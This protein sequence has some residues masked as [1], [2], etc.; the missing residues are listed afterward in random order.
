[1]QP[2]ARIILLNYYASLRVSSKDSKRKVYKAAMIHLSFAPKQFFEDLA[3]NLKI[4]LEDIID[5]FKNS[6]IVKFFAKIGW[7][8]KKLYDK[9]KQSVSSL[10]SFTEVIK[11]FEQNNKIIRWTNEWIKKLDEHFKKDPVGKRIWG[12]TLGLALLVVFFMMA[13][14]GNPTYD[15]D[16]SD[17]IELISGKFSLVSI[18]GG[19][20]GI[21]LITLFSAG[22][23]TNL[24]FPWPNLVSFTGAVIFT[25]ATLIR[26]NL[27]KETGPA[28]ERVV[29]SIVMEFIK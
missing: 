15:F 3:E 24:T 4:R 29:S 20:E 6:A 26:Q 10:K 21:K 17:V 22:T 9:M 1:M 23:F 5:L 16:Y 28:S 8:I 25:L 13:D 14:S 2:S 12:V 7:N 11:N 18:F 19:S 27:R